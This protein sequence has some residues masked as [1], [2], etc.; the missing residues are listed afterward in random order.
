MQ[1]LP[2]FSMPQAVFLLILF[3]VLGALFAMCESAVN[4]ANE[5]RVKKD[6]E[7]G[8]RRAKKFLAYLDANESFASPLQFGMMLMGFFA[9][10]TAV[11]GFTPMLHQA[12]QN[13]LARWEWP[14]VIPA[15]LAVILCVLL[16]A[17]LFL[18]LADFIP[19]KYVAHKAV[20]SMKYSYKLVGM[21]RTLSA[22]IRPFMKLCDLISDGTMRL[23]GNDPEDLDETVTEE[24][25]LHIV[26]EGEELGVIEENERDMIT[27]ILDFNDTTVSEIMTHRTD[28]CAIDET[29][30]IAEVAAIAAEE[31]FSRLPVYRED[32]DTI[33]GI[34][35]VKDF[36][37]YIDKPVPDFIKLS[38]MLRPAYFI[39]ETKKCSRSEAHV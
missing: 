12:L 7:N 14:P 8:G 27:N 1:T 28:I 23:F 36:L 15:V 4:S 26:G 16:C 19:K 11:L 22:V 31:G 17:A 9:I 30:S 25:I 5:S 33:V 32:I 13:L 34:C 39:P 24:E 6:A 21:I 20:R 10:G 29:S 35:Y 38:D 3:F 18:I 2:H 37:P